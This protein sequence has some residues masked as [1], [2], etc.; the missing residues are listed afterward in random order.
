MTEHIY[1]WQPRWPDSLANR[2]FEDMMLDVFEVGSI[3]DIPGR[4]RC[5][6]AGEAGRV[7][8]IYVRHT[9][10]RW[11]DPIKPSV[12]RRYLEWWD[13][14]FAPELEK[15][16]AYGLLG[17]SFIVR[18]P[19]RF[20]EI[21]EKELPTLALSYTVVNV[22]DEMER[23]AKKDLRDFVH[24]HRIPLPSGRLERLLDQVLA[25]TQ[26]NYDLILEAL[27]SLEE[28]AWDL[29]NQ[30]GERALIGTPDDEVF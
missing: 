16:H 21:M 2:A 30:T 20:C 14:V 9:P 10:V 24:T 17:V 6:T 5:R 19:V 22:L 18:H 4:I 12:L 27:K 1:E 29:A 11:D 26:G 15:A 13:G 8:L 3:R 7:P 23:L 28:R 25:Q